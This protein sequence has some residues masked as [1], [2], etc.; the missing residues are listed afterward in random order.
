V[1]DREAEFTE[2]RK[3]VRTGFEVLLTFMK[4]ALRMKIVSVYCF[5][6]GAEL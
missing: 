4:D 2:K 5:Q 3:E 6:D 1:L